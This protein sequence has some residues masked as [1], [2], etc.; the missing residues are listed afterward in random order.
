MNFIDHFLN[1]TTM[2]RLILYYLIGLLAVAF[3]LSILKI[4]PFSPVSLVFSTLFIVVICWVTNIIFSQVFKA[5][6]NAES[7]Y[8]SAFILALIINPIVSFQDIW[9]FFWAGFL[10]MA[11]K[12]I[13]AV[14]KKHIFNPVAIATT[15]TVIGFN[16]SA[17]WWVGTVAMAPF[18]LAGGLLV[19]RKIRKEELVFMFIITASATVAVFTAISGGNTLDTMQNLLFNSSLFFLAFVMLTEPLTTPPTQGWQMAYGALVGFL[20]APRLHIAGVYSTP[21]IALCLGNLFSYLV[22]PKYKLLLWLQEKKQSGVDIIDFHFLRDKKLAFA[23]GQYMEWTLSHPHPDSRG[24]RRYLTIASSPTEDTLCL[25]VK[26]YQNGSSFKKALADLDRNTAI[27]AGSLAGDFT[28][29]K[30]PGQKCVFIAGGIGITPFRSMIKY[31]IDVKQPRPIILFYS[32]K[33]TDEMVYTD[34]FEQARQELGIKTIYTLTD[35]NKVPPNWPGRV[36]RVDALMIKEEAPD[37]FERKF[38]LSG[39]HQM[40]V[41]YE[42]TLQEMGIKN[43]QIK[44]D[45]FP[46]FV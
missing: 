40:V 34:V 15:L 39:P 43:N 17:S 18:V 36:G 21:E 4:L 32:N 25:G 10:A 42:K 37:Y 26:F 5:S 27:V 14:N 8:I 22:S 35:Q 24:N 46:G 7:A 30:N 20:F 45:F 3:I 38:Y 16:G 29:P 9:L 31:L 6:T 19:V 44:M 28:L 2:Y 1:S 33:L 23:P 11:S 41:G 13:L 12:Y